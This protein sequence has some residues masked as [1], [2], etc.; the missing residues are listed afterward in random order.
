MEDDNSKSY[1]H[2]CCRQDRSVACFA[3]IPINIKSLMLSMGLFCVDIYNKSRLR[4]QTG[5]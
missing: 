3:H 1:H 5:F 2:W 4:T